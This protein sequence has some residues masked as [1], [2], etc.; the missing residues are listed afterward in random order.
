MSKPLEDLEKK[1]AAQ[2]AAIE[3][4]HQHMKA[5]AD[6]LLGFMSLL[7]IKFGLPLSDFS[8]KK[9]GT[10]ASKTP[11]GTARS[12]A[13]SVEAKRTEALR[14]MNKMGYELESSG[15]KHRGLVRI[16]GPNFDECFDDVAD[17]DGTANN[18]V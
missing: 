4:A 18:A 3:A 6:D 11:T 8:K 17:F 16:T 7:R 14:L 2:Q 1:V 5:A 9:Y 10:A 12:P 15:R 13:G